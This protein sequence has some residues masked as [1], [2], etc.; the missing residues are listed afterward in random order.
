MATTAARPAT[1]PNYT[2]VAYAQTLP[3]RLRRNAWE[4]PAA[5][6]AERLCRLFTV[7]LLCGVGLF[8]VAFNIVRLR[9]AL[10][11]LQSR[12]VDLD[13][14]PVPGILVCG[15]AFDKVG[16]VAGPW[17]ENSPGGR[18]DCSARVREVE[19][20][21]VASFPELRTAFDP[22]WRCFVVDPRPV[23][24]PSEKENA[25]NLRIGRRNS[26]P[27]AP[28]DGPDGEAASGLRPRQPP[29]A[30][31][32]PFPPS[33]PMLFDSNT[34]NRITL[35]VYSSTR[36]TTAN[37]TGQGQGGGPG[38]GSGSGT[39]AGTGSNR[40]ASNNTG[41]GTGPRTS[42]G[43]QWLLLG[44]F[45]APEDGDDRGLM[46]AALAAEFDWLEA[47]TIDNAVVSFSSFRTVRGEVRRSM[48]WRINTQRAP[49]GFQYDPTLWAIVRIQPATSP[50]FDAQR[51]GAGEPYVVIETQE[52]WNFTG[53]DFIATTGGVITASLFFYMLLW[54]QRRLDPWGIMQRVVF[55]SVPIRIQS[56]PGGKERRCGCRWLKRRTSDDPDPENGAG[57]E[58]EMPSVLPAPGSEPRSDDTLE[59]KEDAKDP[60]LLDLDPDPQQSYAS[61]PDSLATVASS[62][63][64][65]IGLD[66]AGDPPSPPRRFTFPSRTMFPDRTPSPRGSPTLIVPGAPRKL[67]PYRTRTP[68]PDGGPRSSSLDDPFP[69]RTVRV[70]FPVTRTPSPDNELPKPSPDAFHTPASRVPTPPHAPIRR[71]P[72]TPPAEPRREPTVRAPYPAHR[73]IDRRQSTPHRQGEAGRVEREE[74]T[75]RL[76][77]ETAIE[78]ALSGRSAPAPAAGPEDEGGLRRRRARSMGGWMQEGVSVGGTEAVKS[79]PETPEAA[80]EG[81]THDTLR[82]EGC[83][84][85][86]AR[87]HHAGPPTV[88]RSFDARIHQELL[89][90]GELLGRYYLTDV[91]D[92]RLG[93]NGR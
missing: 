23:G 15:G 27:G 8:W 3:R 43:S 53:I 85:C 65:L 31:P 64:P 26:V 82:Q 28:D 81:G 32:R 44:R 63:D 20:L 22:R 39:G 21:S 25:R 37:A 19:G 88:L 76:E 69:G 86:G 36:L 10:P 56:P 38:S 5:S 72:T 57:F 83:R 16:C 18:Q 4:H 68:S 66:D 89:E 45:L 35:T 49:L 42:Q 48:T 70:L 51:G 75:L 87:S 71:L 1:T 2:F 47:P 84:H 77:M 11:V 33:S 67:F 93:T 46:K 79:D 12:Q 41:P 58:I 30:L 50:G 40:T 52:V 29:F 13:S 74:T 59:E 92:V 6:P 80:I 14:V 91:L 61:V 34:T 24:P 55:R 78:R 73:P 90:F 54:G 9:S 60:D 17:N 7:L 62:Q